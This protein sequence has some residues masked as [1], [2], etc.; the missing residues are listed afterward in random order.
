M[1]ETQ[2]TVLLPES[3]GEAGDG[4]ILSQE[5][6]EGA[7]SRI[8]NGV[9]TF[10]VTNLTKKDVLVEMGPKLPGSTSAGAQFVKKLANAATA[11]ADMT[12]ASTCVVGRAQRQHLS[13]GPSRPLRPLSRASFLI[14]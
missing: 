7:A 12:H 14:R 3:F 8:V 4:Q 1:F 10:R 2:E 6:V 5:S 9:W 13:I 11:A